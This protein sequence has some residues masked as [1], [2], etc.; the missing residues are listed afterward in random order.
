MELL[1]SLDDIS[2]FRADLSLY[3]SGTIMPL[4]A[5]ARPG[6]VESEAIRLAIAGRDSYWLGKIALRFPVEAAAGENSGRA[7]KGVRV[8]NGDPIAAK[9]R[10]Q[11][12][13]YIEEVFRVTKKRIFRTAIWKQARYRDA[14]EFERWQRNDSRSSKKHDRDFTRVLTEKP[15]LK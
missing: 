14:T 7:A 1:K 5:E 9:R 4:F 8:G 6:D 10:A 3:Y 13:E 2:L 12:D 15:H 11:V